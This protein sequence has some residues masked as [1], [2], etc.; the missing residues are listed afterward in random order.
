M[1]HLF[2]PHD[3]SNTILYIE[4]SYQEEFNKNLQ[5]GYRNKAKLVQKKGIDFIYLPHLFQSADYKNIVDYNHPFLSIHPEQINIA[6]IYKAIIQKFNLSVNGG[7]LI[8]FNSTNP[9][10]VQL[11]KTIDNESAFIIQIVRFANEIN[12]LEEDIRFQL[13]NNQ[14]NEE[15]VKYGHDRPMFKMLSD[16]TEQLEAE[17]WEKIE[18]LKEKGSL[19]FIGEIIEE[20]QKV[21]QKISPLFI[22]NDYRIFLKDYGMKEVVM[23]PLSKCLFF[24]FLNHPE[25][26][27]FKKLSNYH[28]EL[29]SIYR[30]V[31]IRENID[32]AIESIK[33]M[34]DPL[35]N[36]V[37]EKCSRI[38]S[39]FL[40]LITDDLAKN[41]YITGSRGEIKKIALDRSLVE[42][43]K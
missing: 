30:N 21:T 16:E 42:F 25:G 38:R 23:P 19:K 14:V 31:T 26:I 27:V 18:L 41:Y 39:A 17:I 35:N 32:I 34:T 3:Y 33:A 5:S 28:D 43:Q 22:T 2:N 13:I 6:E 7:C 8:S 1:N 9:D 12:D 20:L 36:S 11:I 37:N 15:C 10:K 29:L 40:E 24:L 4:S